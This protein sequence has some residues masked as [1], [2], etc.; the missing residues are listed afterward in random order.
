MGFELR[1]R[2]TALTVKD[3][4][5]DF[6]CMRSMRG[7]GGRLTDLWARPGARLRFR[8]CG[9]ARARSRA[10]KKVSD[11]YSRPPICGRSE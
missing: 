3:F 7:G 4:P 11:G 9:G 2:E 10:S 6:S 8:A 5:L 1:H